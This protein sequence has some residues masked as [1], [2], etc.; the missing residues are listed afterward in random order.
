MDFDTSV[1]IL[2]NLDEPKTY[3]KNGEVHGVMASIITPMTRTVYSVAKDDQFTIGMLRDL[4]KYRNEDDGIGLCL[5]TDDPNT[6]AQ[7]RKL[8]EERYGFV[9][10][11]ENDVIDD[12]PIMYSIYF[13]N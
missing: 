8:L 7:L 2:Y 1:S 4:I 10:V 6:F 13:K 3:Y 11:I 9:C 12:K 5:V